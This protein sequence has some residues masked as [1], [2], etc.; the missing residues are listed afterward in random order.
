MLNNLTFRSPVPEDKQRLQALGLTAYGQYKEMLTEENWKL[1][2]NIL[3]DVNCYDPLLEHAK[4]FVCEHEDTIIGMA[5]LMPKGHPT[6]LF[7]RE[8]S[9]IRLVGVDPLFSGHGIAKT[10]TGMC[11]DA[12]KESKE[13]FVALHTSEIMHAA[14][15]VYESFGFR[16]LK[17]IDRMFGLR[18]WIYMLQLP[19]LPGE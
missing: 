16:K 2:E 9:Y 5:F 7:E 14:R 6:S 19:T 4:G 13:E 12:A 18:Y 11:I 1:M 8:W 10:L 17:E 15:H 3:S